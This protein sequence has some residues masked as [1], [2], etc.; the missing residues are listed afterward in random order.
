MKQSDD[1]GDERSGLPLTPGWMNLLHAD[2]FYLYPQNSSLALLGTEL[3]RL[4]EM[5]ANTTRVRSQLFN[6]NCLLRNDLYSLGTN[7]CSF[8]FR[9]KIS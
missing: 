5:V 1:C 3:S 8:P 7:L 9:K 2:L 4:L 6:W